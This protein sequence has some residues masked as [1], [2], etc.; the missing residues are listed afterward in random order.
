[1]EPRINSANIKKY[2]ENGE[3]ETV[4]FKS[5]NAPLNVICKVIAAFANTKGGILILGFHEQKGIT[6]ISDNE[7]DRINQVFSFFENPPEHIVYVVPFDKKKLLIIEIKKNTNQLTY[8][9]GS[10]LI[11]RGDQIALMNADEI[12]QYY[13]SEDSS[14]TIAKLSESISIMNKSILQLTEEMTKYKDEISNY[15]KELS[16]SDQ[17]NFVSGFVF[18]ILGVILGAIVSLIL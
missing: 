3:N 13:H 5:S 9:R 2:L 15:K 14:Q 10:L 7:I 12:R 16:K 11:K 8:F 6:G 1:M 17:K 18:C 4:E